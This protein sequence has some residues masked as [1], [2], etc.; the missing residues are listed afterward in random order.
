MI[1]RE[2]P[3]RGSSDCVGAERH[4]R[5]IASARRQYADARTG[6][7]GAGFWP[8][9]G[10]PPHDSIPGYVIQSEIHRG[11][12][13]IV[14]RGVQASTGRAVA[15]KVLREGAFANSTDR[16]R[17][18]RE[19][20][21]LGALHH[22][23]V[24][25]IHDYGAVEGSFYFTMEYI[26][27][28]PLDEYVRDAGR[29]LKAV[30]EVF[31]KICDAVN[32][33]HLLG[34]VHRDIKP[35]NI[36]ITENSRPF[37]L[38]FGLAKSINDPDAVDAQ[39]SEM[40]IAGQFV[41]SLPWAS[42]EQIRGNV[43]DVDTRTDVYSLGVVLYHA[44][45]GKFPYD[46]SGP[47]H[48]AIAAIQNAEPISPH[49]YRRDLP[50][51]LET[52]LLKCLDKKPDRRYRT[53]GDLADD[54]RAFLDSMPISA[55]RDSLVYVMRK[56][57]AR[58]RAAFVVAAVIAVVLAVFTIVSVT[59]SIKANRAAIV[60]QNAKATLA[61]AE[62]QAT[63]NLHASLIAQAR[64]VRRGGTM[65]QRVDALRAL[66]QA[67]QIDPTLEV[68]NEAVAA[69][70]VADL[71]S[72]R[73]IHRSSEASF[74]ATLSRYA[75]LQPDLGIAIVNLEEDRE[76]ARIPAPSM[77]VR[78]FQDFALNGRFVYRLFDPENG[79]RR[80]E[81]WRVPETSLVLTFD[82]IPYRS[83]PAFDADGSRLAV[84]RL[85]RAIHIYNLDS[86][87]PIQ[88][89]PIDRDPQFL[90]FDPGGRR[91]A[92]FHG[93]YRSARLLDLETGETQPLFESDK[94]A[95]AI[96][97]DPQGRWVAGAMGDEIE[98]W[99]L[100]ARR[101]TAVLTGHE[102][103][104]VRLFASPDGAH[105]ASYCWSGRSIIWDV[106]D[107]RPILRANIALRGFGSD[108]QTMAALIPDSE[109]LTIN[110]L[111]LVTDSPRR[112]L[113]AWKATDDSAQASG[114]FEPRTGLLFLSNMDGVNTARLR[115][116]DPQSGRE[117][118]KH[119]VA[120]LTV[121]TVDPSGRYLVTTQSSGL[122]RWAISCNSGEVQ[123]GP[124]ERIAAIPYANRLCLTAN[125]E[126]ALTA[127]TA[128]ARFDITNV[129]TGE[130]QS[131]SALHRF[132]SIHISPDGK[133]V[134]AGR[135]Y[136]DAFDVW[137]AVTGEIVATIPQRNSLSVYFAPDSKTLLTTDS[138]GIAAWEFGT[139]RLLRR[140]PQH[141]T[142]QRVSPNGRTIVSMPD[143]ERIRLVDFDSFEEIASLDPSEP[144]YTQGCAVSP[145]GGMLAQLTSRDGYVHLWDL[146]RLR[147]ELGNMGLDWNLPSYPPALA[148][149][150]VR[151]RFLS[152]PQASIS[153]DIGH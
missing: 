38:D 126:I 125:G 27:G 56:S 69:L 87:T 44:L 58:H 22:P 77:P 115:V 54:L 13:G 106:R 45:T 28:R 71:V 103:V 67:A 95:W 55:R 4:D 107:H 73:T 36:L 33:V 116:F 112:R 7:R 130:S 86:L 121:V 10:L 64:A 110:L 84:G 123:I 99:D 79:H 21:V 11:G 93:H 108:D 98:I 152:S 111:K 57:V 47:P 61:V 135:W 66:R 148:A 131:I 17:F 132:N 142:L 48:K 65:G 63:S 139:W 52:I 81:L 41:G 147:S 122:F 20:R 74:D 35:R 91:I 18:E 94:I 143:Y 117:L 105:L 3:N 31:A 25:T 82:D 68:R 72:T 8:V 141:G 42:P 100:A 102:G 129:V 9:S 128:P 101:R 16:H 26:A 34:I 133:W 6:G 40:T 15:I 85:D 118:A 97:W 53:A 59:Y 23:G 92:L 90:S 30:V 149:P 127:Q 24:V 29:P 153:N 96:A 76:I 89:I 144:C 50:A 119:E 145:D 60:A 78:E 83:R 109:G 19:V 70:A 151:V 113:M 138:D 150:E 14:Y 136:Q 2:N 120:G 12:Q 137:N 37:V 124:A 104:I 134:A 46:L 43:A 49:R 146:R 51:D 5:W 39:S 140:G 88:R 75:T 114:A 80:L 62:R 1:Q 32:A